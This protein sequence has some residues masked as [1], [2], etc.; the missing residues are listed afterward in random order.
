MSFQRIRSG[1]MHLR[2]GLWLLPVVLAHVVLDRPDLDQYQ[3][4]AENCTKLF[5][6][7]LQLATHQSQS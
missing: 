5:D 1:S 3:G 6:T 7:R 4:G 2:R